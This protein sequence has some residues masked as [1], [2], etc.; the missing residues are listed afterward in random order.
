MCYLFLQTVPIKLLKLSRCKKKGKLIYLFFLIL[1]KI[2][3]ICG[4]REWSLLCNSPAGNSVLFCYKNDV[5][6][7]TLTA[8]RIKNPFF[9]KLPLVN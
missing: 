5:H 2:F 6:H 9:S 7:V 8:K 1:N 4:L 3:F